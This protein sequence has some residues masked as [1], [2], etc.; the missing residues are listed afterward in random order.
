MTCIA[1]HHLQWPIDSTLIQH[2]IFRSFWKL[3]VY[4]TTQVILISKNWIRTLILILWFV[5][6]QTCFCRT[7]WIWR[8]LQLWKMRIWSALEFVPSVRGKFC[9]TQF[10]VTF[11]L[12]IILSTQTDYDS[13]N[14][15]RISPL[16]SI[17]GVSGCAMI[18]SA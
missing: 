18:S 13:L 8:C 2:V 7:K 9:W 4:P 14:F 1:F 17:L 6:F 16:N 12:P 15:I 3:L 5:C 11:T 10:K